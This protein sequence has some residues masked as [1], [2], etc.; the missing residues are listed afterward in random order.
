MERILVYA[1]RTLSLLNILSISPRPRP[2]GTSREK[3]IRWTP[4]DNPKDAISSIWSTLRAES[5]RFRVT[6]RYCESRRVTP[7]T[8]TAASVPPALVP[9]TASR[10]GSA[11]I[12][13]ALFAVQA[14]AA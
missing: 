3:P 4:R 2:E 12:A 11:P 7:R 10:A 9:A 8:T 1:S 5:V 6:L 14:V 13:A